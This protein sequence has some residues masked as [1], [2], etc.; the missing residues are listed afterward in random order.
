MKKLLL[1]V[2]AVLTFS[3]AQGQ[4]V[5]EDFEGTPLNWNPFGDGVFNGVMDNPDTNFVNN[6][7]KVGSYTKSDQ[8]AYSLL[9]AVLED[10]MDLSMMNQF[11]IDIYSPVA[12][13]VLLKIEGDGEF[14][15]GIRNIANTDVWQTYTFD[16]SAA[17]AMETL[18][19]IIIF[20]DPGVMESGDTYL[21]DNIVATAAGPCA[22]TAP[23]P[24]ILDDYECQRNAAY[25]A[26]WDIIQAIPNPDASGINTSSMVGQYQDPPGPWSALVF[27]FHNPLDL[28]VNNQVSAKIWSPKTGQVLFKLEGGVSP[29]AEIFLDVTETN[30]WVEYTADFSGQA[31]ANHK[32]V[33]VF[34][35]AGVE[36]DTNDVYFI[37]DV[38][39]SP[40]PPPEAIEDFE[41]GG[42]LGWEPLNGDAA[43][44]GSFSII[45][46]PDPTAPN[47]TANVGQ[48]NKGNAAFSTLSAFLPQG[49]D[50][51]S[52]PQLNM[53]VWA[54]E[55]AA[56]V[57]MQLVSALQGNK[58]VTRD[59]ATTVEW[60]NLEFNFEEF[61]D[62]TDFERVNLIFDGGTAAP[63]ATYYFDNIVQGQS[64][65]D[66]CEGVEPVSNILDDFECQRNVTYG[67]GA[68]VLNVVDNPDVSEENPSL[69]VGEYTDPF[70][71]WSA[72]GF[73]SGGSWDLTV[74]NQ[75]HIKI[76]APEVVP[77]LFKMEGGSSAAFEVG[78]DVT[79]AGEWVEYVVDFSSQ[80]MEDHARIVV[81]FEAGQT[82]DA[83]TKYYIDDIFWTRAS[84]SGCVNDYES[85]A[86][87][88][89]N[90][91]YF[92]NGTLE[93]EGYAF[94]VLENPNPTGI[95]TSSMVGEFVKAG[96]GASFA[97]MYADL[98][99]PIDFGDNKTAKV[100]VHMD[101]IG[102]FAVKLEGSATGADF[103][104]LPV[105]N[106][107]VNDWEE[108][109]FDFS[110]VPDDAQ[111]MR[112]TI[113]FDL[114][115][116]A[117]G[118][119]V[120]SYFDDMVFGDGSCTVSTGLFEPVRVEK[121]QI[122]PNPVSSELR[123]EHATDVQLVRIVNMLGQQVRA[124]QFVGSVNAQIDVSGLDSGVY[125]L[126]GYNRDGQLISNAKFVKQ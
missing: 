5:Y 107:V 110:A 44:H 119:N 75:F 105:D 84:Y 14:I 9:I 109:T 21:F 97:G 11:S 37:D 30:T 17:A 114:G 126:A 63:G 15:E 124:V 80:E 117:T 41:D 87:T 81:F 89:D 99:A 34:F 115:I 19:K 86:T 125:L 18:T 67:V 62:I 33:V 116:D 108:L 57:T 25:G 20:F 65:V 70:D 8:H 118:E 102:N 4:V 92:A 51:S 7:A 52:N 72:L 43:N 59:L 49:L 31:S 39:F 26:G 76:W 71:E 95:N 13:Q 38:A 50:L 16:F 45:A 27:D 53:H 113:F 77:L 101:H 98:D 46:N 61:D 100:K 23:D 122:S 73:E 121:M 48:Y 69:S 85:A 83:E 79:A 58:D 74:Q 1:F 10:T 104:E 66:P 112:L 40:A 96:D 28:S 120:T 60:T 88:I 12:T 64:T 93:T 56:A 36:P 90:F 106:T 111:Y 55:G 24:L 47:E 29:P 32:K 78:T 91:R 2:F 82:P 103:V 54:P 35:N 3:L 42:K 123:I 22:G 94:K 68:D 6:S